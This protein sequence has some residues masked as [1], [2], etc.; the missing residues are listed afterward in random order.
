MSI[1]FGYPLL[2]TRCQANQIYDPVTLG[3]KSL[4]IYLFPVSVSGSSSLVTG[5]WQLVS[6]SLPYPKTEPHTLAKIPKSRPA[7]QV[8]YYGKIHSVKSGL[9]ARTNL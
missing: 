2:V 6:I 1:C 7:P 4:T 3:W 8:Q 9:R 5:N